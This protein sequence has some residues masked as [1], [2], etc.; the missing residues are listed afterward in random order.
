MSNKKYRLIGLT[1]PTGAGKSS[2]CKFFA[3]KGFSIVDADKIAHKALRDPDCTHNL[4][5]SFGNSILNADDS[6][7]RKALAKCAFSDKESTQKLNSI[8]HPAI[9][10]LS[11]RE[12]EK[13]SDEG[14][15]SIVFDAPTLFEAG[16]DSLCDYIVSVIAPVEIRVERIKQRDSL[17]DEQAKARISAQKDD[18]FYANRSDF[19]IVND[20]DEDTLRKRTEAI[21]K[22]IL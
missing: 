11:L 5:K 16:M 13:L 4:V 12:F 18:I 10:K 19:V 15:E 7:N 17:N 1:G 2:V 9:I 14:F 6:I 21:I 22:E 8:T 3:E 20:T